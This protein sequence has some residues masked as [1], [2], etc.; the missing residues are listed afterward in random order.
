MNEKITSSLHYLLEDFNL[1]DLQSIEIA[2]KEGFCI[3]KKCKMGECQELSIFELEYMVEFLLRMKLFIGEFIEKATI[4]INKKGKRKATF[5]Y[6]IYK[7]E[8]KIYLG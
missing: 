7:N 4:Q 2:Q 6:I 5:S 8:I 1:G 3:G